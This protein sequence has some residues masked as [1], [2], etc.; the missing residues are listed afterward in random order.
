MNSPLLLIAVRAVRWKSL[1]SGRRLLDSTLFL[2][3]VF[4]NEVLWFLQ[5]YHR[6]RG[7]KN[8]SSDFPVKAEVLGY[9]PNLQKRVIANFQQE[10]GSILIVEVI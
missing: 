3:I 9:F 10:V 6:V 8:G 7:E 5:L 4:L 1:L 2:D